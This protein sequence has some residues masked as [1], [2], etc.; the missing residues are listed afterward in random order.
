[1]RRLSLIPQS[2]HEGLEEH[3]AIPLTFSLCSWYISRMR[4]EVVWARS[5][6]GFGIVFGFFAYLIF[7]RL[8][9]RLAK[10]VQV[11]DLPYKTHTIT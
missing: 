9:W 1:V 5:V 3:E 11:G 4:N 7:G 8:Q 6:Q 10:E 2:N